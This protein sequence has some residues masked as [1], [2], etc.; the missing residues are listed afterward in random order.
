MWTQGFDVDKFRIFIGDFALRIRSWVSSRLCERKR[1][2]AR[3]IG[4]FREVYPL[5]LAGE[6]CWESNKGLAFPKGLQGADSGA[7]DFD[8]ELK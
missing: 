4:Y 8:Y 3:K 1:F 2:W 6:R 7:I 5:D